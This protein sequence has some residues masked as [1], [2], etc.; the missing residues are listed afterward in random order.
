MNTGEAIFY[1]LTAEFQIGNWCEHRSV[2]PH[3]DSQRKNITLDTAKGCRVG[4]LRA[5]KKIQG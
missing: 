2:S 1:T 4:V 3:P 5:K